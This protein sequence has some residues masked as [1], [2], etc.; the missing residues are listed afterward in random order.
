MA[1]IEI[2]V[3]DI[4]DYTDVPVIEIL[5]AVGD[6]VAKDQGLVTLESDKA[7]LE[8]PSSA[9]G[10]IKELKVKLGDSLSEGSV[11]AIL[12]A[13][14]ATGAAPAAAKP[15]APKP[16]VAPSPAAPVAAAPAPAPKAAQGTGR[17]PDIECRMVV[18]GSGPGGYTAAFRA[19]DIGLETVMI[20]RYASLGGVCL[21]V[22][23]IPSKALLHAAALIEEASHSAE[24]GVEFG[25]PKI[26]LDKLRAFKDT[27]VVGQFTK[28][29]AGMAK[30]RKV[31]TVQGVASFVSPNELEI[32]GEDGKT[33]LLRFEQCIIAA[34]SQAVKLPAFPWDDPRVMDSTDALQLAEVPKQL[35]VVGGGII[36]LEMATVYRALGSV[37]TVVEF[38]D[39][40]MPGADK[41][42][43]KPLADRL[44]KQGVAIHL[45]T[46][47]TK[48]EASKKGITVAFESAT[49]GQPAEIP[50]TT[51]DRVLVAVGRSPNGNKIGADKAGVSVTDRGFIPVDKQMRT[52][53][54]H[55]FAIGDVVGNPMLAHKATHEGKLAAE[56]A[57]GEKKEWVARV[58]PSVAYTDPEIAWVGVTETEAKAKGLKVGVGKF[59]WVASA[60]AVGIGRGEGFTKLVLDEETHRIIGGAIVGVHAGDLITEVSLAIE[61][62]ADAADIGHTIHPHPTLS[63]SVGMAA[64]VFDGTITDLYIPK[65]K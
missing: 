2:K 36:G 11:V 20:E 23:C 33:Q 30:Q 42:L 60:R 54:P 62:G 10:V 15:E 25:P 12:E 21:N 49:E 53:V 31:R 37:V 43:V 47:A 4:G 45:K 29:L 46:K 19:A 51:F 40:L 59:P 28:G 1:N 24:I 55:I 58:I 48:V 26:D 52:N 38:M 57:A 16:P 18:L 5:V 9:A 61:M 35:L 13:E 32:V 7:T 27:K 8:V 44:K 56:V 22:G 3:P 50:T 14:G 34:G 41:D 6:T 64:E 17:T 63:E 65:K 39:Q